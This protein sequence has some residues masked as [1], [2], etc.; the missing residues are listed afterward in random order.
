MASTTENE[1]RVDGKEE[2]END[3]VGDEQEENPDDD[4][5][6]SVIEEGD[7]EDEE[8]KAGDKE[9]EEKGEDTNKS[10]A[11]AVDEDD[12][13]VQLAMEMALAAM[14]NPKLGPDELR[15][16]VLSKSAKPQV[17][18][19]KQKNFLME[20]EEKKA[21]QKIKEKEEAEK[22]WT[23]PRD[24]MMSWFY[25]QTS[26]EYQ[27][28]QEKAKYADKIKK[29]KQIRDLKKAVKVRRKNLKAIR[30]QG[31]RVETRH[32]FKRQRMEKRLLEVSQMID[33]NRRHFVEN[34]GPEIVTTYAKAMM[35]AQ[36][37]WLKDQP[38]NDEELA[39]EA[40]LCRNMHQ[41]LALE[42]QKAKLK[43][44]L[45]ELKKYLQRCKSWL[46]DKQTLCEQHISTLEGTQS[47][48]KSI[49]DETL[50]RQ[51]EFLQKFLQ[52]RKD[53]GEEFAERLGDDLQAL[54]AK[55]PL[56]VSKKYDELPSHSGPGAT[57]NA[58][59]GLPFRDSFT[60]SKAPSRDGKN[61]DDKTREDIATSGVDHNHEEHRS[62]S[63]RGGRGGELVIHTHDD[64][65]SVNSAL[66]DPD[67]D[68]NQTVLSADSVS[69]KI[70]FGEDAPWLAGDSYGDLGVTMNGDH[71]KHMGDETELKNGKHQQRKSFEKENIM[72]PK[73]NGTNGFTDHKGTLSTAPSS[74]V[75]STKKRPPNE[76]LASATQKEGSATPAN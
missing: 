48:M 36:K 23:D 58:L 12:E 15:K 59:R 53:D 52:E 33:K 60:L 1:A 61:R 11:P 19:A 49:Y 8:E 4:S 66:S 73:L 14:K 67:E 70:A 35:K 68:T 72:N 47:S 7:E 24:S 69:G 17:A 37:K 27:W 62:Q 50:K 57:L 46:T 9:E 76:V 51:D 32:V 6:D 13:E 65:G 10:A 41:M 56:D 34:N 20:V 54:L 55:V 16:L 63:K 44:S 28:A 39:L 31:N 25:G 75:A 18:E 42:K 30:L 43:K 45:K 3:K 29:D 38:I 64:G 22:R 26:E 5:S 40:Q 71:H 74:K 2:E 21:R